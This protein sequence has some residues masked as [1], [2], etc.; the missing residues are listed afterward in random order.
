MFKTRRPAAQ[1]MRCTSLFDSMK[2]QVL[3]VFNTV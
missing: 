2:E 3:L 1:Q